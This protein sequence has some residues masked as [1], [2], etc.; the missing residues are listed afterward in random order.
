MKWIGQEESDRARWPWTSSS[1]EMWWAL[2]D[3]LH[4]L[5][6]NWKQRKQ[7]EWRSG[8]Y[9]MSKTWRWGWNSDL[10]TVY[11]PSNV[12]QPLTAVKGFDWC[13]WF[14]KHCLWHCSVR[15]STY[16]LLNITLGCIQFSMQWYFLWFSH[17][18]VFITL[19]ISL[20]SITGR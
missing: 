11:K 7:F 4:L 1:Q 13:L 17:K 15:D 12:I 8:A 19:K 5:I 14:N 2:F 10:S 9:I 18:E 16:S 6:Q 20:A 3:L